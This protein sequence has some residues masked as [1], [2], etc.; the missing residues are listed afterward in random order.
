MTATTATALIAEVRAYAVDHYNDGGW[1]VIVETFSDD[2]LRAAIGGARTLAGALRK[3]RPSVSVWA[4]RDAEARAEA[5]AARE[6]APEAAPQATPAQAAIIARRALVAELTADGATRRDIAA[7]FGVS[8]YVIRNDQHALGLTPAARPASGRRDQVA[9]L[10]AEG[11]T[12]AEI[13]QA[14][15]LSV[16][17]TRHHLKAAGLTAA[18]PAADREAI[19]SRRAHVAELAEAGKTRKEIAD[20]LGVTVWAVRGDQYAIRK[21]AAA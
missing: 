8:H 18:R 11:K 15:G 14:T 20:A 10:A 13:A 1:D 12:T 2:E 17:G 21:T 5:D 7:R 16:A 3:L 6:P 4:D 19:I 9:A